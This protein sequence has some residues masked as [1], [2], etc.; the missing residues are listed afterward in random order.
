LG[1]T[2][3]ALIFIFPLSYYD[4][5]AIECDYSDKKPNLKTTER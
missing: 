4:P 1:L 3:E 2:L 5:E